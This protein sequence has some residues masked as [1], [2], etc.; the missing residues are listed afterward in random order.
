MEEVSRRIDPVLREREA[1]KSTE[2]EG[3]GEDCGTRNDA[4]VIRHK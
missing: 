2:E 1:S 4:E 3:D